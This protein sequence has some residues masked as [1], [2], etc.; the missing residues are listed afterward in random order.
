MKLEKAIQGFLI[1]I[2]ADGYSYNT[3]DVYEWG[4]KHLQNY[5]NN[6]LVKDIS[7]KDLILATSKVEDVK[8]FEYEL[9]VN[10]RVVE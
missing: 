3:I 9:S 4:L 10:L 2:T 5:L 1:S 8:L 6:P 7:D